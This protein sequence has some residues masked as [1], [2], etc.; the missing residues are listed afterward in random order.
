[1]NRIYSALIVVFLGSFMVTFLS[2]CANQTASQKNKSPISYLAKSDIDT[3]SDIHLKTTLKQLRRLAKKL[4]LRN[5]K[6][7]SKSSY[8]SVE[9]ALQN[10][11]VY[12]SGLTGSGDGVI[13]FQH[14]FDEAYTGDRVK[15][16]IK[17][18]KIMIT[19]SYNHKEEFFMFDE[20][21]PQ[22]LYNCARNI[23]IAA[24]RLN[25]TRDTKGNLFLLSNAVNGKVKNLSFERLF[26]KLISQQDTMA[27]IISEQTNR[28]IKRIVQ[29]LASAVFL[30]I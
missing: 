24:W 4:Y 19:A 8:S 22:K 21:D 6:E 11:F 15:A 2:S 20:L 30:P 23:E 9:N 1:M 5:P 13:H 17:G 29:T 12:E 10:I 16:F 7:L 3:V 18:L 26:G 14:A 25:N 28:N 27:L